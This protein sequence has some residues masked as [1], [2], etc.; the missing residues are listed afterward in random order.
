MEGRALRRELVNSKPCYALNQAIMRGINDLAVRL[1][2]SDTLG[3][4]PAAIQVWKAPT[5][6]SHSYLH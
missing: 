3:P 1:G 4:S 2:P 6:S 5:L